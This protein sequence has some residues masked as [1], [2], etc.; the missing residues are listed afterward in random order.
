MPIFGE[1]K[2]IQDT[3]NYIIMKNKKYIMTFESF[4]F[5]QNQENRGVK[6]Y[7][8]TIDDLLTW[9]FGEEWSD[10]TQWDVISELIRIDGDEMDNSDSIVTLDKFNKNKDAL[11]E[12][13]AFDGDYSIDIDFAFDEIE[14]S[15][16]A[17]EYPFED[18]YM[19]DM[20]MSLTV[21]IA[22][23][24]KNDDIMNVANNVDIAQYVEDQLSK[25]V[26]VENI[27]AIGFKNWFKILKY[28]N[29]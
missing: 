18:K 27:S 28:G 24:L 1:E 7:N 23:D 21:K 12:V 11:I 9:A 5:L 17:E 3:G 16:E 25:K 2:H 26:N 13:T 29:N 14:Y 6:V 8:T 4:S 15:F 20:E 19:S 22:D 10:Y